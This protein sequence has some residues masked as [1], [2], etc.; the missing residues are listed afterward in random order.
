MEALTGNQMDHLQK[1]GL[2]IYTYSNNMCYILKG[3]H[4]R[5]FIIPH[6]VVNK[7][8]VFEEDEIERKYTTMSIE[9][10]IKVIPKTIDYEREYYHLIWSNNRIWYINQ[11]NKYIIWKKKIWNY[12]SEDNPTLIEALYDILCLCLKNKIPLAY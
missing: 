10:L 9:D 8:I 11:D 2:L 5:P 7:R 12:S 1:L 3:N 6:E 4:N